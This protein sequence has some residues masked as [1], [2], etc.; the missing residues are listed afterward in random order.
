MG[1]RAQYRG[2]FRKTIGLIA[3]RLAKL[4]I[5]L[6]GLQIFDNSDMFYSFDHCF[7]CKPFSFHNNLRWWNLC[8]PPKRNLFGYQR[9]IL[10]KQGSTSWFSERGGKSAPHLRL[11]VKNNLSNHF[12]FILSSI[13]I[14]RG[15]AWYHH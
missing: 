1:G 15:K 4:M 9:S 3:S 5:C 8:S 14:S 10:T 7:Y 6:Y 11:K 2:P 13:E 12:W